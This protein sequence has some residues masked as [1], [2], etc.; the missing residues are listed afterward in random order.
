MGQYAVALIFIDSTRS[1]SPQS[2]A[3]LRSPETAKNSIN[4]Q[5]LLF[6]RLAVL[7]SM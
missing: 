3:D 1:E 6:L 4:I 5:L 7:F 2:Q